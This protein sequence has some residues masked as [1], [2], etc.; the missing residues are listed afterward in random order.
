MQK[1]YEFEAGIKFFANTEFG[2]QEKRPKNEDV[3]EDGPIAIPNVKSFWCIMNKKGIYMVSSRHD[4]LVKFR[5]FTSF[6][7][8]KMDKSGSGATKDLGQFD[9]GYCTQI[10]AIDETL[11]VC[12]QNPRFQT[13]FM[14]K[15]SQFGA[16]M[17]FAQSENVDF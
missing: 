15:V 10:N 7:N 1:N 11:V 12:F 17:N 14:S 8:L 16:K 13:A 5:H 9:E 4:P 2:E 6:K 3:D